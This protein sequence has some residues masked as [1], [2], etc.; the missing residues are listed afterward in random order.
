MNNKQ[1]NER[2]ISMDKPSELSN[3]GLLNK[4]LSLY[5]KDSNYEKYYSDTEL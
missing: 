4:L 3:K 5:S 1:Q 2:K